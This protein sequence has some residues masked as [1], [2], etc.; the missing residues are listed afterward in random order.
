MGQ[1]VC[2]FGLN[3]FG[4]TVASCLT[5]LGYSVTAIDTDEAAVEQIK[6][7]VDCAYII[8]SF[9]EETLREIPGIQ[10]ADVIICAVDDFVQ[11]GIISFMSINWPNKHVVIA[12]AVNDIHEKFLNKLGVSRVVFPERDTGVNLVL[13][14]N[15]LLNSGKK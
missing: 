5:E 10:A 9:Q 8:D 6:E 7:L 2:V 13:E 4:R 11:S 12:K 3:V 1:R 14:L 15:S